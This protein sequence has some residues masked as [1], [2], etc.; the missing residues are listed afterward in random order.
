[1]I[2]LLSITMP[3]PAEWLIILVIA[4]VIFGPGKLPDVGKGIGKAL[5][6]F[7]KASIGTKEDNSITEEKKP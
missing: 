7:K 3:G 2:Q 6:E 4:L 5:S 1:M